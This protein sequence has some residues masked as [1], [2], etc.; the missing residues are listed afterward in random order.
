MLYVPGQGFKPHK[1]GGE[2]QHAR[3]GRGDH[4]SEAA[5]STARDL[6]LITM[7]L[8]LHDM[9]SQIGGATRFLV[10]AKE[11]SKHPNVGYQPRAGNVLLFTQELLHEGAVVT[12]GR[13]F[14]MRSEVMY[15]GHHV[16]ADEDE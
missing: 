15:A 4:S 13:K 16:P 3:S 12:A 8:Y 11:R 2:M 5:P 1:D 9:P 6:S 10:P 14:T 7:Q